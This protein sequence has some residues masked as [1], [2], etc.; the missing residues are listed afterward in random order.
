VKQAVVRVAVLLCLGA[1]A[2]AAEIEGVEFADRVVAGGVPLELH[3]TGLL[4][5]RI[6]FK[7]YVAALYLGGGA[8]AL[9]VLT[10]VPK[11]LEL[12]YFWSI[13]GDDF[14]D[15]ADEI[16]RRNFEPSD[17][18]PLRER[19][20]RIHRW[21]ESVKPGDRYALTYLPGEGTELSLNGEAKGIV[22][23]ADFAAAYFAIWLGRRPI[24]DSLRAQ[25]LEPR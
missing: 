2:P 1:P 17:L 15:A 9:D 8:G 23:G 21:F 6:V 7:A 25:L 14:G 16:L 20:D 5:Y 4:R 3:G 12:E 19:I 22:P 24:D 11:R 18:E 13:D 10:D